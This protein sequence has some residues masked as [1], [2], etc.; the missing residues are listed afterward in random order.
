MRIRLIREEGIH[1]V[2]TRGLYTPS[3][4]LR[5]SLRSRLALVTGKSFGRIMN[6]VQ[7]GSNEPSQVVVLE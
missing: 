2:Y 1:R 7:P 4:P 6:H 3:S 5:M